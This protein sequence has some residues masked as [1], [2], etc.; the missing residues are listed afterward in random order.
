MQGQVRIGREFFDKIKLDYADWRFALIREFCQ[1]SFDAPGCGQ[2]DIDISLAKDGSTILQVSNDGAPMSREVLVDKLLTLGGSGKN[3][4]G[5]NCGGFGVAKSLLYYCHKS[6][7][8]RTGNLLISGSGGSYSVQE[9][10]AHVGGT[11]STIVIDGSQVGTL[12]EQV[13]RFASLAQWQGELILNGKVLATALKKGA[14]RRDL[15][16]AV[17]YTNQSYANLCVVRLNG[18]PMFVMSTRFKGCVLVE[19]TGKAK[20][21]LTSNRDGLTGQYASELGELLTAIAVDKKSA[22]R[23]QRAE[24]RRYAGEKLKNEA[25]QPRAAALNLAAILAPGDGMVGC[26]VASPEESLQAPVALPGLLA[27]ASQGGIKLVMASKEDEQD[28]SITVGPEFILKNATGRKLPVHYVPG[29]KFSAYCRDLIRAW[30]RVLLKLHQLRDHAAEFSVGFVFDEESEAEHERSSAYGRV[31]YINPARIANDTNR[32]EPRYDSLAKSR[33]WIISVACHEFVHGLGHKEH[34]EDYAGVLTEVAALA[35]RTQT[36][37]RR[38]S[39][40]PP[41]AR[42]PRLN[43]S[44]STTT[45]RRQ[46]SA[47]WGSRAG[48]QSALSTSCLPRGSRSQTR[49]RESN[50]G[51]VSRA[52]GARSQS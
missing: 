13:E 26:D 4:E 43:V 15:G 46:S 52:S 37:W 32:F 47:G 6:Y 2:V 39:S 3:F 33:H 23:E 38:C 41:P 36:S 18:Q 16:W 29:E 10:G 22:L 49:R 51:Q 14:R 44:Y 21:V 8:I 5:E 48:R 1:N 20:D 31:Y 25:K 35:S 28:R 9:D 27:I 24:Y 50:S 30:T 7:H 34:D 19:L 45:P 42:S 40:G 17:V 11:V 12:S